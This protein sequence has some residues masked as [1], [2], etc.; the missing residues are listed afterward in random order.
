MKENQGWVFKP[1]QNKTKNKKPDELN[2]H[3][4][5]STEKGKEKEKKSTV[6]REK[7]KTKKKTKRNKERK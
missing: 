1:R 5:I 4:K 7:Q 3:K 2:G 6:K